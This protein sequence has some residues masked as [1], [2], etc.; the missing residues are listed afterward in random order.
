MGWIREP[1]ASWIRVVFPLEW[2]MFNKTLYFN[3][4]ELIQNTRIDHLIEER[5]KNGFQSRVIIKYH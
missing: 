5:K 1:W 2:S 4:P 3:Q